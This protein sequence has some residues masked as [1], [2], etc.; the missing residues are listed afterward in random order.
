MNH[1]CRDLGEREATEKLAPEL[2]GNPP[3]FPTEEF[4][5]LSST[6]RAVSVE[7]ETQFQNMFQQVI[8]A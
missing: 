6:E 8:G 4:L 5:S 1:V 2:V 7:E 3:I